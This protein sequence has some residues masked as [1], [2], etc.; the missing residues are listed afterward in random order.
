LLSRI[1]RLLL[2]PTR[3]TLIQVFTPHLQ[4]PCVLWM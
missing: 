2:E 4:T 1:Y 3:D